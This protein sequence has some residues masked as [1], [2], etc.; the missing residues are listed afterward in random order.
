LG[1]LVQSGRLG[2]FYYICFK[3]YRNISCICCA[4]CIRFMFAN[5]LFLLCSSGQLYWWLSFPR[6]SS[7]SWSRSL[8]FVGI[9]LAWHFLGYV[10]SAALSTHWVLFRIRYSHLSCT[11]FQ[12]FLF[13]LLITILHYFLLLFDIV[14]LWCF[15]CYYIDSLPVT[16]S[17][18]YMR[19]LGFVSHCS[20]NGH[21]STFCSRCTVHTL[22]AY[23][24]S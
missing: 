7:I 6:L 20:H 15:V 13:G 1:L 11:M 2:Y 3:R 4:F 22:L 24:L 12:Y 16:L 10:A 23:S 18:W 5:D 21:C 8:S 14:H 17:A 19:V 9:C